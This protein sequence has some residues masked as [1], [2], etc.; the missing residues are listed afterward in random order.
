MSKVS[1]QILRFGLS[2]EA[3]PLCD[4]L[5]VDTLD[6]RCITPVSDLDDPTITPILHTNPHTHAVRDLYPEDVG[7]S[8]Y[9]INYAVLVHIYEPEWS[10]F[11]IHSL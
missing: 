10:S 9:G 7:W 6:N 4:T 2:G 1:V 3:Q 11:V 5:T 8:D